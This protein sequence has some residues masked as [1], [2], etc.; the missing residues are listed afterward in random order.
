MGQRLRGSKECR[1]ILCNYKQKVLCRDSGEMEDISVSIRNIQHYLYC[2]HR[3]GLINIECSWAENY[4]VTK[5]NII[6]ERVHNPD[7]SY[8]SKNK[9]V[10][11]SVAVYNDVLGIYGITD[12]IELSKF[13]SGVKI[14]NLPECYKLTIVEYK[15]HKPDDRLF[16]N[17]DALQVFAQK[18]CV[19]SIFH[20]DS[21]GVLYYSDEKKRIKLPFHEKYEAY[22]REL[23]KVLEEIRDY[24]VR[25][26]IP[27][28][29]RNQKCSG[30][31]FQDLCIP[32]IVG[33]KKRD[34]FLKML[35]QEDRV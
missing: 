12:C 35:E 32:K 20:C 24:T 33:H 8:V 34:S 27:P 21:E 18:M 25:G 19:D 17:D 14:Q 15:P 23:K 6:H 9:K 4:F 7:N 29:R 10:I 2:P 1:I 5:G 30:C 22:L 26:E 28:I 11:T 13:R 16:N 31:S 3:W